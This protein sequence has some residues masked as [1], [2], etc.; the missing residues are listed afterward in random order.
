MVAD[1]TVPQKQM[2]ELEN[3]YRWYRE[4]GNNPNRSWLHATTVISEKSWQLRKMLRF[5]KH[6]PHA[7]GRDE[8]HRKWLHDVE[9]I[10][11]RVDADFE[12]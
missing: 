12:Q 8:I 6:L 2:D 5:R 10:K 4:C 9:A 1:W 7:H 3:A 11:K